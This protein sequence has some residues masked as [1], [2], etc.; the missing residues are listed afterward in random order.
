MQFIIDN[1]IA[2]LVSGVLLMSLQVTQIRSQHASIE[3]VVSHSVKAKTIVF[4][5]WVEDD[6]LNLGAN[7]GTNLY[8]FNEPTLDAATGN[9]RSWTF[10]SDSTFTHDPADPTVTAANPKTRRIVKRYRLVDTKTA[11]FSDSTYQLYELHRD[12]LEL[13][14]DASG[15]PEPYTEADWVKSAQSISTLSFFTIDL[16]DRYGETPRT[17]SGDVDVYKVDY[18][19]VRFGVIPEYVL[20]PDNYIRELYWVKTL[21]V[22]PYWVP[23]PSL[24]S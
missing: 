13:D 11:T 6:I 8:R 10:F 16:L 12:Y 19:R 24:S 14:L 22:R 15:V 21:K 20:K 9:A 4:G 1:L 3:Q 7:F 2:V 5:Q 17:A 18:V 23:P